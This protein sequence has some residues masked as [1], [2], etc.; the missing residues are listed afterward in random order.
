ML[1]KLKPRVDFTNIFH[2]AVMCSDPKS[3]KNTVEPSEFLVLMGFLSVT[4]LRKRVDEIDNGLGV[5]LLS[6]A[7]RYLRED[8]ATLYHSYQTL[9]LKTLFTGLGCG[10]CR[11]SSKSMHYSGHQTT[12]PNLFI[13]SVSLIWVS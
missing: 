7:R 1:L 6:F 10:M 11:W 13:Q 12:N 2:A 8:R 4:A 3:A 9:Y 5:T